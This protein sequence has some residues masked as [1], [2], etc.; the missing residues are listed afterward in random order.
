M[1]NPAMTITL[2]IEIATLAFLV[3]FALRLRGWTSDTRDRIETINRRTAEIHAEQAS[4]RQMLARSTT[5]IVNTACLSDLG[6]R[7][8]VFLADWSIDAFLARYL[9]QFLLEHRPDCI[10]ELGSGSS[11]LLIARC[12]SVI[13]GYAPRHIVIDHEAKYLDLTRQLAAI[14]GFDKGIE[15]FHCPLS[16]D[17]HTGMQ[18]YGGVGEHLAGVQAQLIVVDGPPGVLQPLSRYPAFPSLAVH[19]AP[20]CTL[21]LDDAARPDEREIARRWAAENPEFELTINPA[22]HGYAVLT[23]RELR[24]SRLP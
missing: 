12:A 11:T 20:R 7:Y 2:V 3:V 18:W 24:G 1:M 4:Q 16:T 5:E 19:M 15:Y 8:P 17:E 22:G 23:R 10:V 13:D 9:V 6:F 21:L 14:N